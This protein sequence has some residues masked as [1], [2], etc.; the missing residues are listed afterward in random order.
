MKGLNKIIVSTDACKTFL[1]A[2]TVV[3]LSNANGIRKYKKEDE[4]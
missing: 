2:C 4:K 1:F 3:C